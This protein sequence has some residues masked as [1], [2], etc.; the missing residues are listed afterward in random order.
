MYKRERRVYTYLSP[1]ERDRVDERARR[2]GMSRST[3]LRWISLHGEVEGV[4]MGV[5]G[6]EG[7]ET[8][9]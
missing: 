5:D 8:G 6:E 4:S 7:E 3:F 2:A 9:E 1:S